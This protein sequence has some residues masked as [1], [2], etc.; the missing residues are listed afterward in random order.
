MQVSASR[1]PCRITNYVAATLGLIAAFLTQP[2]FAA[3]IRSSVD[4][5]ALSDHRKTSL[6]LHLTSRDAHVAVSRE[7]SLLFIDVRTPEEFGLVGHPASI[8]RN[9]PF[10][11]LGGAYNPVVGQYGFVRNPK[12]VSEVE[13]YVSAMGGSRD[14]DVILICRSGSRSAAA[15][16]LLARA[17]F[18]HVWSVVDGFEGSADKRGHRTIGG[19]RNEALPWTYRID[20]SQAYTPGK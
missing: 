13:S 20:P 2:T 1:R 10:A 18:T 3:D 7:P 6:G 9:I 5:A 14:S 15:A 12:F 19:W 17:G 11:W 8:D 4:R 16:D